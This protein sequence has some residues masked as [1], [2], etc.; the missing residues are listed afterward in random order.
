[1]RME[2]DPSPCSRDLEQ[3]TAGPDMFHCFKNW[4]SHVPTTSHGIIPTVIRTLST[5]TQIMGLFTIRPACSP[6]V[7]TGNRE[8]YQGSLHQKR[9]DYIYLRMYQMQF[10]NTKKTEPFDWEDDERRHFSPN[11]PCWNDQ[12]HRWNILMIVQDSQGHRLDGAKTLQKNEIN[13]L[14]LNLVF[15]PYFEKT[16]KKQ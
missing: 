12:M 13:Y 14:S 5:S 9:I 1:M 15:S 4:Y 8:A 7:H 16:K 11:S 3:T 2:D 10:S 6:L